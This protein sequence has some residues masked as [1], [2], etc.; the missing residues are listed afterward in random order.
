[1]WT[2]HEKRRKW[3]IIL[4]IMLLCYLLKY[5]VIFLSIMLL[6]IILLCNGNLGSLCHETSNFSLMF[7][8]PS[9]IHKK[10]I[11]QKSITKT[12]QQMESVNDTSKLGEQNS[13]PNI[14]ISSAV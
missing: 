9:F 12:I 11:Y 14:S 1:M 4:S 8:H 10:I 7:F 2:T 6:S 5:C 3:G 13:Y